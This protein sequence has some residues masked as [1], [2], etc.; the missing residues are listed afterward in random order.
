MSTFNLG[1]SVFPPRT[2][3]QY[4]ALL[5]QTSQ[6]LFSWAKHVAVTFGWAA[7]IT[8]SEGNLEGVATLADEVRR[9]TLKEGAQQ[10]EA[11]ECHRQR[12]AYH[13]QV[14]DMIF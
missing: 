9:R 12:Y 1:C 2:V 7:G 4:F 10:R 6:D 11:V 5:E 8:R 14:N 13:K 3:L